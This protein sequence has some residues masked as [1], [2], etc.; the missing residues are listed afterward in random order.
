MYSQHTRHTLRRTRESVTF[1]LYEKRYV[2]KQL[3]RHQIVDLLL[4][5]RFTNTQTLFSFLLVIEHRA[6]RRTVL[7]LGIVRSREQA[8]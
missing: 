2:L 8:F 6:T 1:P 3:E 4:P 7:G 5:F